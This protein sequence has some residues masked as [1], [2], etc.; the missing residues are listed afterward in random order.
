MRAP[1]LPPEVLFE[2]IGDL[3][4]AKDKATLHS[5]LLVSRT[6]SAIALPCLYAHLKLNDAQFAQLVETGHDDPFRRQ[7]FSMIQHLELRP[8]PS[9]GTMATVYA[10]LSGGSDPLF[11]NVK[12]LRIE[13]PDHKSEGYDFRKRR[14]EAGLA[15]FD[16]PDVC[17]RGR[18]LAV[19]ALQYLP[20]P[21]VSSSTLTVHTDFL[22][23]I[24]QSSI[25]RGWRQLVVYHTEVLAIM[26]YEEYREFIVMS[27]PAAGW[28]RE[29]MVIYLPNSE[30]METELRR[31]LGVF[32]GY[33]PYWDPSTAKCLVFDENAPAC[34]V[35]GCR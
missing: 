3:D 12:T 35:C 11:P 20:S 17:I 4:G 27:K 25:P 33:P 26:H 16:A 1:T 18:C 15:Q 2:I 30:E 14:A 28:S 31:T 19:D 24:T 32:E 34:G 5:L 8:P 21:S 29:P 7:R 6:V 9:A 22:A 10:A 23:D 13:D